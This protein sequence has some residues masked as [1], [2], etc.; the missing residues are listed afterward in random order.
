MS[1][2]TGIYPAG[3]VE[4]EK[5]SK[6]RE[7]LFILG[8][9]AMPDGVVRGAKGAVKTLKGMSDL[10]VGGVSGLG[11]A[12][13]TAWSAACVAGNEIINRDEK[14][15]QNREKMTNRAE[16]TGENFVKAETVP[17]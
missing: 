3:G 15:D 2:V 5:V 14:A 8:L 11:Y 4:Q 17:F 10:L 6:K 9:K 13:A 7:N 16:K 1:K 12:A